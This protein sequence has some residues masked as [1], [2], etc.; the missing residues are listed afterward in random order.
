MAFDGS[1]LIWSIVSA[2]SV[3]LVHMAGH[4]Y[5]GYTEDASMNVGLLLIVFTFLLAYWGMTT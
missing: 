5:F 2:V 1:P 3:G 4:R